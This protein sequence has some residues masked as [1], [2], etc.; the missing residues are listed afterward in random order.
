MRDAPWSEIPVP[1]DTTDP[2]AKAARVW[3]QIA[4]DDLVA[5]DRMAAGSN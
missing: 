4:L 5:Q 2:E 1:A 3:M